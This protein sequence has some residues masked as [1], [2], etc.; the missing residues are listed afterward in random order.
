MKL[1]DGANVEDKPLRLRR[2][3]TSTFAIRKKVKNQNNNVTRDVTVVHFLLMFGYKLFSAYFPLFLL[4]QGMSLSQVGWS[5]LLI[6]LPIA[7]CAPLVGFFSRKTNPARV[8]ML[9]IS[10][11]AAYAL[12]MIFASDGAI[13]YLWQ[14]ALGVSA[15]MFFT[16]SRILL[17]AFPQQNIERGMSW[18]YSAPFWADAIAPAIGGF[19]IWAVGFKAVF[20]V[21]VIIVFAALIVAAI[22]LRPL[23]G[24]FQGRVLSF[25]QWRQKWLGILQKMS[26]PRIAP[27]LLASLAVLWLGGIFGTFFIIYL[28]NF[29]GWTRDSVILYTAYSS[30]LFSIVYVL[31]IRPW[32]KDK[33][34]KS[35]LTGAASAGFFSMLFALPFI[36]FVGVF[37]LDFCRGVAAFISN[38]GR[39]AFVAGHLKNDPEEAAAFDT[40]FSPLGIALGSLSAGLLIGPL[41]YQWLFFFGGVI[42][43]L[44]II[45][46]LVAGKK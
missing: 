18:F 5:Y 9:G 23:S 15:S 14:L 21:S 13:L 38:T 32:Q 45:P 1:W 7:L 16:A 29:L 43:L 12:A 10:G 36:N 4:A 31:L 46:A 42:T 24:K 17:M 40:I 28:K 30:A 3:L 8:M 37:V 25:G 19:L 44:A 34:E 20:G 27:V 33:R 22:C 2:G 35:V 39:S 11:Y 6:Y 26:Q 41:G